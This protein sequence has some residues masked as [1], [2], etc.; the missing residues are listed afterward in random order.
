MNLISK[1]YRQCDIN[2]GIMGNSRKVT[3]NLEG[4]EV[5]VV[6]NGYALILLLLQKIEELQ[7]ELQKYKDNEHKN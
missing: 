1:V 7:K 4:E 2:S 3:L 6:M 5:A